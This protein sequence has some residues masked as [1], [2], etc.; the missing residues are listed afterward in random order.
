[1]IDK[2]LNRPLTRWV[3]RAETRALE[4]WTASEKNATLRN[5]FVAFNSD[6]NEAEEVFWTC[7]FA[8]I[9]IEISTARNSITGILIVDL[10]C[11]ELRCRREINKQFEISIILDAHSRDTSGIKILF[12]DHLSHA[13]SAFFALVGGK[14][15]ISSFSPHLGQFNGDWAGAELYLRPPHLPRCCLHDEERDEMMLLMRYEGS[16]RDQQFEHVPM[17]RAMKW[18]CELRRE[19]RSEINYK[20]LLLVFWEK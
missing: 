19:I 14:V 20:I 9:K 1:M 15:L 17:L 2:R 7:S 12:L 4:R 13:T 8:Q 10:R 18:W 3:S 11:R 5:L 6:F 16:S